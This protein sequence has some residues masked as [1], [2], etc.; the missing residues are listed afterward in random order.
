MYHLL[1]SRR[2]NVVVN[3]YSGLLLRCLLCTPVQIHFSAR[4]ILCVVRHFSRLNENLV[5]G[6][7]SIESTVCITSSHVRR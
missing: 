7:S 2:C 6:Y 3:V 4:R 5:A 1:F